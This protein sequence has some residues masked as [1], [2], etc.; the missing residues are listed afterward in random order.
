MEPKSYTTMTSSN[1]N[2]GN[3]VYPLEKPVKAS[4]VRPAPLK[5]TPSAIKRIKTGIKRKTFSCFRTFCHF[6]D[7]ERKY[8][9]L[10]DAVDTLGVMSALLLYVPVEAAM[11]FTHE[12]WDSFHAA[13]NQCH[14]DADGSDTNNY[15][16]VTDR[17]KEFCLLGTVFGLML[18]VGLCLFQLLVNEETL[19]KYKREMNVFLLYMLTLLGL[20]VLSVTI[21]FEMIFQWFSSDTYDI[22]GLA[23]EG[24]THEQQLHTAGMILGILVPISLFFGFFRLECFD[25]FWTHDE[26]ETANG[27]NGNVEGYIYDEDISNIK[28]DKVHTLV[29]EEYE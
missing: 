23:H 18:L 7:Y 22:C 11:R 6:I 20:E 1:A 2:S 10:K 12:D 21:I 14:D 16:H 27:D 13:M 17:Y 24:Y 5:R 9:D 3:Q 28:D 26:E 19:I 15:R 29:V 25:C 8:S 4:T